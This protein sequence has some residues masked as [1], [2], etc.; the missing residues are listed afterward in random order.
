[1]TSV[2]IKKSR[3][4]KP[5]WQKMEALTPALIDETRRKRIAF[6]RSLQD[7]TPIIKPGS[8]PVYEHEL[9]PA[10]TIN[11]ALA[12]TTGAKNWDSL[13]GMNVLDL[14]CGS[15]EDPTRDKN[16]LPRYEPLLCLMCGAKGANTIGVDLLPNPHAEGVYTHIQADLVD[17]IFG[18]G[19]LS[20]SGLKEGQF[21]IISANALAGARVAPAILVGLPES[22]PRSSEELEV[23]LKE[24]AFMLLKKNGVL[25]IDN[26]TYQ[27]RDGELV[28]V[29]RKRW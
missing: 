28:D 18:D 1:M 27:K 20:L 25:M 8:V 29:T 16:G 7:S 10:Y 3:F 14:G 19:L 26:L 2:I 11:K 13:E 4:I 22:G 23:K 17:V 5:I 15:P 24:Q 9:I 12:M 6:Y 21:D